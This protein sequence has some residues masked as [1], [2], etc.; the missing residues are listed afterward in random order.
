MGYEFEVTNPTRIC[1]GKET[2][3]MIEPRYQAL[4]ILGYGSSVPTKEPILAEII[5]VR[6]YAEL[7]QRS[8]EV[9]T[10]YSNT[11]QWTISEH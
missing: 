9:Q 3:E 8:N 6:D 5:V 1:R 11:I 7:E 10:D 4:K 2:L